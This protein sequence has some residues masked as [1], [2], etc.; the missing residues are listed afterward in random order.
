[1]LITQ[2]YISVKKYALQVSYK[3]LS[4]TLTYMLGQQIF[5]TIKAMRDANT[6]LAHGRLIHS[7]TG[8]LVALLS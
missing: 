5:N 4:Q 2:T 6:F 1:M 3:V 8:R 7:A